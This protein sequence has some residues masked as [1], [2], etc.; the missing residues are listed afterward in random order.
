MHNVSFPSPQRPRILVQV[1]FSLEHLYHSV[2]QFCLRMSLICLPAVGTRHADPLPAGVN[3]AAAQVTNQGIFY[4]FTQ[5][6]M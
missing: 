6:K 1:T 5:C 3:A 4:C 2:S